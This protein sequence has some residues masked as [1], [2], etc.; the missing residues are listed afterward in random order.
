MAS[1]ELIDSTGAVWL[2]WETRPTTRVRLDPAFEAGWLTFQCGLQLR[3][4]A[5][6][7]AGWDALTDAELERL[8]RSATPVERRRTPPRATDASPGRPEEPRP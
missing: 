4:L 2:V 1:R 6:A 8:C 5:P 3:R 7:P